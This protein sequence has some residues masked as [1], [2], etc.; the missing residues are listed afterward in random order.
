MEVRMAVRVA[1][2]AQHVL[3]VNVLWKLTVCWRVF[4][5]G[6]LPARGRLALASCG[7]AQPKQALA[8]LSKASWAPAEE[9]N[10]LSSREYAKGI[11][12][13]KGSLHM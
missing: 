13:P 4:R 10:N 6:Q 5:Q 11:R 1:E 8:S 12:D 9:A 2:C 7:A 3:N